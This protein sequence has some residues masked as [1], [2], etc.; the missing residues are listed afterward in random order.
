MSRHLLCLFEENLDR[1]P[2]KILYARIGRDGSVSDSISFKRMS[3]LI[4]SVSSFLSDRLGGGEKVALLYASAYDFIPAFLGAIRRGA[5]P[6]AFQVPNSNFKFEKM[7][8]ILT[9]GGVRHILVSLGVME[10][11]W[12]RKL[13]DAQQ[14]MADFEWIVDDSFSAGVEH[15]SFH[16]V[17]GVDDPMYFQLSSGSS[18]EQKL[19]PVSS[20]NVHHN[21]HSVGKRIRREAEDVYLSWLPH[22][23]D[24]GLVGALFFP[25]VFG[26]TVYLIDPL[27]FVSNPRVW[28]E[29]IGRY[30]VGFTFMPNFALDLCI[31]RVDMRKLVEDATL[32]PLR[33]VFVGA[34]PIRESTLNGFSSKFASMGFSDDRFL[35]GYGMAESTLI[36]SVKEP[37]SPLRTCRPTPGGRAYVTCGQPIEGLEVHIKREEGGDD[38]IGE[39]VVTGP[40]VSP[41]FKDGILHTGDLGFMDGG[42][43]FVTGRKRELVIFKGVKY[44]LHELEELAESLPFVQPQGALA[45]VD[46]TGLN[47]ELV[48]LIELR[49]QYTAEPDLEGYANTVNNAFNRELGI[50]IRET[51]F[52]PPS[53]L[54]KTSSGK[55]YRGGWRRLLEERIIET[56]PL[57]NGK[58]HN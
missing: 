27:D 53:S 58:Q 39:V 47:E 14:G 49:R 35:V 56:N 26:N 36:V 52:Y 43:L 50:S 38:P 22:Y 40:S 11:G 5:L 16:S 18:G 45:C 8:K 33:G 29:S 55:K 41:L 30:R 24:L 15:D 31:K 17:A 19:I 13:L 37:G 46:D 9:A 3:G 44:M 4:Q 7:R 32:A 48:M 2:D 25:L 12:F 51:F 57:G 21:V 10:K 54:P 34:E 23:H 1:M 28:V 6:I 20:A 42:E